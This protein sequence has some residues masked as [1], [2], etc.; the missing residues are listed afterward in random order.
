MHATID[1]MNSVFCHAITMDDDRDRVFVH[2]S[3]CDFQISRCQVGDIIEFER[4]EATNRGLRALTVTYVRR[5]DEEFTQ[6]R[7]VRLDYERKFAFMQPD[8]GSD[9]ALC[10][11]SGFEDYSGESDT[12][13]SLAIGDE[14]EGVIRST[15]RGFRA[16]RVR[17]LR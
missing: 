7:I 13:E 5:P 3:E 10:H 14:V 16:T 8:N 17:R 12:F 4:T 6:G 9:D 2:Q 11:I 1:Q 15:S